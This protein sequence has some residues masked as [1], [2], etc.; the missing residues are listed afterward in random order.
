MVD[1]AGSSDGHVSRLDLL[2]IRWQGARRRSAFAAYGP[3]RPKVKRL[4]AGVACSK[5]DASRGWPRVV[6][7]VR[8]RGT[9]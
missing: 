4:R 3:I 2:A 9:A 7:S 5:T 8:P 6:A 1:D